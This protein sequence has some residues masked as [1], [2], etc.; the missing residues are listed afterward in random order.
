ALNDLK[1]SLPKPHTP[2]AIRVEVVWPNGTA[3][4]HNLLQLFNGNELIKNEGISL[5]DRPGAKHD[6][7]VEF[8]GYAE[9]EYDLH[10]LYWI[11]DLGGSIPHDQ[12][13]IARSEKILLPPGKQAA[14]VR[15]VLTRTILRDEDR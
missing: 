9:R 12:Q 5:R 13:R 2:R 7:V 1:F 15:L 6:G 14:S 8:T 4:S 11:D 3:P 10:A